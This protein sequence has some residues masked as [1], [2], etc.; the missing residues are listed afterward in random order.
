MI[1]PDPADHVVRPVVLVSTVNSTQWLT[2]VAPQFP[3]VV[4]S[5]TLEEVGDATVEFHE[6]NGIQL[7]P[8]SLEYPEKIYV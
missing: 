4:Q 7:L 3:T 2:H 8:P 6:L 5:R 1:E